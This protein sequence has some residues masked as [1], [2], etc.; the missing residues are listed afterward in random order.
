MFEL[1]SVFFAIPILLLFQSSIVAGASCNF[2]SD[3]YRQPYDSTRPLTVP[4][5]NWTNDSSDLYWIDANGAAH[6]V[7]NL[8]IAQQ[9]RVNTFAGTVFI[10]VNR[11]TGECA[12]SV[13]KVAG[14]GVYRLADDDSRGQ[15]PVRTRQQASS[16][17]YT[18]PYADMIAT[19]SAEQQRLSDDVRE[20]T[21][22]N[23]ISRETL[24]MT[25]PN[26][27]ET[28]DPA[29][30]RNQIARLSTTIQE[31]SDRFSSA[32]RQYDAT[33]QG[34]DSQTILSVGCQYLQGM[35]TGAMEDE[36]WYTRLRR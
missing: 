35:T 9:R 23:Y 3:L 8:P 11:R 6:F 25:D 18:G 2:H 22:P 26:Y 15:A 24:G 19:A 17:D 27:P 7:T 20:A 33:C 4:F 12:S 31:A 29:T 34:G 16:G 5:E 36:Q 21:D 1:K 10:A 13:F 32:T 14:G 30:L 28:S